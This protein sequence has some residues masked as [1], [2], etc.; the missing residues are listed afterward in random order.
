M[1]PEEA[2]VQA[3]LQRG[4]LSAPQ[5]A[6]LRAQAEARG[7][8]LLP[9]LS[10]HLSP[11][12][13]SELSAIHAGASVSPSGASSAKVQLRPPADLTGTI[14]PTR[15]PGD[16]SQRT[17]APRAPSFGSSPQGFGASPGSAR[18]SAAGSAPPAS[19]LGG[20][21]PAPP[22]LGERV[23]NYEL[24]RELGRGGMGVVYEARDLNLERQVA[25][26]LMLAGLGASE[27]DAARFEVEGKAAAR[28]SH[29]G[30]VGVL[31]LGE[32]PRGHYL[33]MEFVPGE[34]LQARLLREGPLPPREAAR[35]ALQ[36]AL[37]LD[38]AHEQHV[39]HRDVKPHNVLLQEGEHLRARLTDFGLAKLSDAA[40]SLTASGGGVLG[41]PAYMAPEQ[42]GGEK[43][44]IDARSDVYGVGA[45]LFAMLAAQPPFKA[46][47]L[48][49]VIMQ[50]LNRPP[51][52]F[53]ELG[54]EVPPQ[55][56]TIARTCLEKEPE[57][58]YSCAADLAE[59]LDRFLSQREI[60]ARGPDLGERLA[61]F[62]RRNPLPVAAA[63][64]LSLLLVVALVFAFQAGASARADELAR[65]EQELA[66]REAA[67]LATVGEATA[68]E[69]EPGA[70]GTEP[71]PGAPGTE[72]GPGAPGTEPG[73]GAPG[74]GPGPGATATGPEP[75]A[76]ATGPG[77]GIDPE[78]GPGPGAPGTGPGPGATATGP[79]P[80]ATAT[81]PGPGI[82]PEPVP[83][84]GPGPATGPGSQPTP[85][86]ES[87]PGTEPTPGTESTPGTEPAPGT[88]PGPEGDSGPEPDPALQPDPEPAR[89]PEPERGAAR[90]P[91][92]RPAPSASPRPKAGQLDPGARGPLDWLGR[93]M[94]ATLLRRLGQ[95]EGYSLSPSLDQ[96][97]EEARARRAPIVVILV[98]KGGRLAASK[99]A[100]DERQALHDLLFARAVTLVGHRDEHE[101][102]DKDLLRARLAPDSRF[103]ASGE[104]CPYYRG[105]TCAEHDRVY[106]ELTRRLGIEKLRDPPQT[107]VLDPEGRQVVLRS[108]KKHDPDEVKDPEDLSELD[109]ERFFARKHGVSEA[110][111]ERVGRRLQLRYEAF[112]IP[113]KRSDQRLSSSEQ[114]RI[115]SSLLEVLDAERPHRSRIDALRT[116]VR[117]FSKRRGRLHDSARAAIDWLIL[118]R[119]RYLRDQIRGQLGPV[120][121][122]MMRLKR[123]VEDHEG[124][125]QL[126]ARER[127]AFG[128]PRRRGPR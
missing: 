104:P 77:P 108:R 105:I 17:S 90:E 73:P 38:Y 35:I 83:G 11:T 47:T 102:K 89:G 36:L 118:E 115:V 40:H 4:Y 6:S 48:A 96:A 64:A 49:N 28:L 46:E 114:K 44:R 32:S 80:G 67:L 53:Q 107:F 111:L 62:V 79:G 91:A 126:L 42:A 54:V 19:L 39:L 56:E 113:L 68:T 25:L 121:P 37:A 110:V 76:T 45:T 88:E 52:R 7:V 63:A 18:G 26:K 119:T 3:A 82:D 81:G 24:V 2:V 92:P 127:A 103:P 20:A 87:T 66:E 84:P 55:L 112:D 101:H 41:T 128:A 122:A 51:P 29:E 13:R 12:Q 100:D 95:H 30:I 94:I 93:R 120:K 74:T 23:G 33:A 125:S 34:S 109:P 21:P 75:G 43:G 106:E 27:E 70:P 98:K 117:G 9:L 78:P 1:S 15:P 50:V 61:R 58:R 97:I 57:D 8:A 14:V 123:A 99:V 69:P 116:V 124:A 31:A 85:V 71:G 60:L 86:T 72:P 22:R 16:A 59:D 10:P 5:L 65:R